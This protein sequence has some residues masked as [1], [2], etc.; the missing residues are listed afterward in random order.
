MISFPFPL[1]R[2]GPN[3]LPNDELDPEIES[4]LVL[5]P[6]PRRSL[7]PSDIPVMDPLRDEESGTGS[8]SGLPKASGLDPETLLALYGTPRLLL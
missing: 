7:A 1:S 6:N 8:S 4:Q 2:F 5:K 3:P